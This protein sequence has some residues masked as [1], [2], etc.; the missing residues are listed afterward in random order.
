LE[1]PPLLRTIEVLCYSSQYY[2]VNYF[3]T[4]GHLFA[5]FGLMAIIESGVYPWEDSLIF[6]ILI[7]NQILILVFE[8]LALKARKWL[9]IWEI[10]GPIETK[11]VNQEGSD[12]DVNYYK[13]VRNTDE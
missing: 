12:T 7:I 5:I 9:K 1:L 6:I 2:F 11:E 13:V 10:E 8:Y 3:G 4:S